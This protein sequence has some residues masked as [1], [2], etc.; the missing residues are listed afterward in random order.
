M[1]IRIK[2]KID[3]GGKYIPAILT[4]EHAESICGLPIVLIDGEKRARR[5][6]QVYCLGVSDSE[7]ADLARRSGYLVLIG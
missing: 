1:N 5:P 4:N 2:A 6:Y 3:H 7:M